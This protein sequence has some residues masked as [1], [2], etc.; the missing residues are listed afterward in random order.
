MKLYRVK[1]EVDCRGQNLKSMIALFL[2]RVQFFRSSYWTHNK[3]ETKQVTRWQKVN[4]QEN[5]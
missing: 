4:K 2:K 3:L 1:G 5:E